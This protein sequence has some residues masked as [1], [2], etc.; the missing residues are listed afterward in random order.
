MN[1]ILWLFSCVYDVPLCNQRIKLNWLQS[2]LYCGYITKKNNN[3]KALLSQTHRFV[4]CTCSLIYNGT[5]AV[6]GRGGRGTEVLLVGAVGAP[7]A[8]G[9]KRAVALR[10]AAVHRLHQESVDLLAQVDDVGRGDPILTVLRRG[11]HV[12]IQRAPGDKESLFIIETNSLS[13][14]FFRSSK[15]ATF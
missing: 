5:V 4:E 6:A 1:F 14:V 15:S 13:V 2:W 7:W 10:A 8:A 3:T 12:F 11:E 9:P